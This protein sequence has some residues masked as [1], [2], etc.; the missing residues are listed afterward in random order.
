MVWGKRLFSIMLVVCAACA[1]TPASAGASATFADGHGLHVLS[2]TRLDARLLEISV[3]SSALPGPANVRVLLP[4]DYEARPAHR[5][6]VFYLLHGTSGGA[7]DWTVKGE[8][9]QATAGLELIVV[10]PDIALGDN[11]GGWCTNWVNGGA[12]GVPEWE[13][14]HIDQL[15]PW[16]DQNLRTTAARKARAI[17]GLSQGGFCSTSYAARH[18]DL[19]STVLGYSGAPDIAF[20][21][22][23]EVGSTAIIN[24]TEVGLDGV[25][26][27][28]MFGDRATNE[29]NW[30][31]HD[32]ATLANNLR[33]MNIRMYWGTGE[34]GP[35]DET[36]PNGG[37]ISI[38][39][40]VNRD[41]IDF[42][43]RLEELAIP[44]F[45]NPYGPG[46]HSWTYWARALRESIGPIVEAFAHPPATPKRITYTSAEPQYSV[47]GWNVAMHRTAREFSTLESAGASGFALAGSGSGTVVTA[48]LYAPGA[49]YAVTLRGTGIA[50]TAVVTAGA[51][52]RLEIEVP[53]G[54]SNPYQ[55]DTAEA[56]AT[57]TAVYTT[58]VTVKRP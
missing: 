19:F 37:A 24:A 8:A 39:A 25:A 27:N 55:E 17:A 28:S 42:R 1:L 22:D 43:S 2:V 36:P 56:I 9:E 54:P 20:S 52:R 48:P 35:L 41:N 11:G 51:D 23:V 44:A 45:Y 7:A 58:T 6:P 4:A 13:R 18:P 47:Y 15:I 46:T 53:L 29:I 12:F 49:S 16:V 33:G 32:P 5:F 14:F 3:A 34:P 26:P 57:G 40:L 30:A 21:P 31:A 50:S 38:E 10:M